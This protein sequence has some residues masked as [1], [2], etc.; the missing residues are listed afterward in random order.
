M[1]I[2]NQEVLVVIHG[3]IIGITGFGDCTAFGGIRPSARDVPTV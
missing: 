2:V 3:I 1:V